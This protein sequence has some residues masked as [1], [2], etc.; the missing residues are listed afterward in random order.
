M[1][2]SRVCRSELRQLGW[3][4]IDAD[5]GSVRIGSAH[6]VQRHFFRRASGRLNSRVG[7][8]DRDIR[9]LQK[10]SASSQNPRSLSTDNHKK[11]CAYHS[12][13]GEGGPRQWWVREFL[14]TTRFGSKLVTSFGVPGG[15]RASLRN[16]ERDSPCCCPSAVVLMQC[17]HVHQSPLVQ[18]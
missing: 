7:R 6:R 15:R 10:K 1:G 16:C 5:K 18:R 12:V 14:E 13:L 11:L 17:D 2:S 4:P 3:L 9:P 8:K